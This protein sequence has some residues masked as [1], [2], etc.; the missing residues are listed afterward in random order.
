M[1]KPGTP[2][3]PKLG[4]NTSVEVLNVS[5]HGLWLLVNDREYFL[6]HNEFPWFKEAKLKDICDV[7]LIHDQH[8]IWDKLNVDLH[9]NSLK[10]LE[11][12]PLIYKD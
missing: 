10:N 9:I 5:E 7:K 4:K 3:S 2:R 11:S 6:S 1:S 12:Y 8:L